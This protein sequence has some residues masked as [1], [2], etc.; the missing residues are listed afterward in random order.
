MRRRRRGVPTSQKLSMLFGRVG[1]ARLPTFAS[2]ECTVGRPTPTLCEGTKHCHA[3]LD[4]DAVQHMSVCDMHCMLWFTT[5]TNGLQCL[6]AWALT[7][8]SMLWLDVW[9]KADHQPE[10][11]RAFNSDDI[12][13]CDQ[14]ASLHHVRRASVVPRDEGTWCMHYHDVHIMMHAGS[15]AARLKSSCSSTLHV[16]LH[17]LKVLCLNGIR[18]TWSK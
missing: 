16:G 2:L 5:Q 13:C 11:V 9:C 7:T 6:V 14:Q 17:T 1:K 15:R 12:E 18:C 10:T 8:Q 3:L 4:R